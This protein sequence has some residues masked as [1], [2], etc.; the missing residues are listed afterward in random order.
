MRERILYKLN[1]IIVTFLFSIAISI[2]LF[3]GIVEDD[4]DVSSTENRKLSTLPKTGW[5]PNDIE[6]FPKL[7]DAYYSDHFG[8]REWLTKYY[9]LIKF[10]IGDSPSNDVTL[11]KDGWL[12]LGSI[13]KGYNRYEDPFGDARNANLYSNDE[14]KSF[15]IYMVS[16]K[17]WLNDNGIEYVFVIAPNKH[18]IYFDKLPD[19]ISKVNAQSSTDQLVE[20][21][22]ANTTVPVVDLRKKLIENKKQH[23]LYYKTDTH[24]NHYAANIAQYEIMLEIEKLYPE[25]INPE[26]FNL[27]EGVRCGGDLSNFIGVGDFIE[28]DPQ[29]IFE[30]SCEPIKHP[31]DAKG[32]ETHSFLCEEQKLNALIFRDSFFT[33]LQP[34]FTR[35]FKKS[36]Y[37]WQKLNYP[38]LKKHLETENYDIVIEAWVERS[39]PIVPKA[40]QEFNNSRNKK[41]FACSDKSI[42]SNDFRK[43]KYN[44]H[45][46]R[47]EDLNKYM[48]IE[49]VGIDPIVTFPLMPFKRDRQYMVH[50]EATSA[51]NSVLQLFY[52]D[53]EVTG[54]PFSENN[55]V[56]VSI[57]S[58]VND[59]YILLDHEKLGK[60]LRLDPISG[61]GEIEIKAIEIREI[62]NQLTKTCT[63]TK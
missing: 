45:I 38:S 56:R 5:N 2:P 15:A 19:Y 47:M 42:F 12:F 44:T 52:S 53:S 20:Y 6:K 7:F 35:K 24:W 28:L 1:S 11:G 16:L 29:P 59:I 34:Y 22:K 32:R 57:N 23:Q 37:I 26:I 27:K 55:S 48:K 50:I 25:L 54:S 51:I 13:K 41:L 8:F 60:R 58:G 9:K 33:A 18:T 63:R 39:L 62:E 31:V 43:L 40:I 21:L 49:S 30:N 10:S 4:K 36:T 61:I 17:A 46:K 3:I 14:L